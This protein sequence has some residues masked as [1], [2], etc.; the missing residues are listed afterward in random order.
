[1]RSLKRPLLAVLLRIGRAITALYRDPSGALG[2]ASDSEGRTEM[3]DAA[4][5]E[6][7]L[8]VWC[9]GAAADA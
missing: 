2:I 5:A 6:L 1:M 3:A 8:I 9:G 4:K 7:R